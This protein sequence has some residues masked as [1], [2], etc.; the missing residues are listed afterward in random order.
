M[1]VLINIIYQNKYEYKYRLLS[2][3]CRLLSG[4][5]CGSV[6]VSVTISRY[7]SRPFSYAPV[8]VCVFFL[9]A[10]IFAATTIYYCRSFFFPCRS[11]FALRDPPPDATDADVWR[12]SPCLIA[13]RPVDRD[14]NR[15]QL[16]YIRHTHITCMAY[17]LMW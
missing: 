11:R 3:V 6:C 16:L 2:L 17:I 12:S 1:L 10:F 14:N 7:K 4:A 5:C 9:L 15:L 13:Q 8:W